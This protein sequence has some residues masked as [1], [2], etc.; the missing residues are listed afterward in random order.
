MPTYNSSKCSL[1]HVYDIGDDLTV[2]G[3]FL[4]STL[5]H[6]NLLRWALDQKIH[7]ALL[8]SVRQHIYLGTRL[9]IHLHKQDS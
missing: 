1:R 3:Q 5:R 6:K 8:F 2:G 9:L 7:Q 4:K